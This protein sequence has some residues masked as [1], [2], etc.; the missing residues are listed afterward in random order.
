MAALV[1]GRGL[2]EVC[3]GQG[4]GQFCSGHEAV[5]FRA[6]DADPVALEVL[7][8]QGGGA[9]AQEGVEDGSVVRAGVDAPVCQLPGEGGRVFVA[10]VGQDVPDG[11]EGVGLAGEA[12]PGVAE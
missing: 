11:A 7:G 8:G 4:L 1:G 9:A 5:G 12:K 3:G 6:F 10:P 2:V